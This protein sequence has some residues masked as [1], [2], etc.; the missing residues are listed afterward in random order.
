MKKFNNFSDFT[1]WTKKVYEKTDKKVVPIIAEQWYKDS[2]KYIYI[3]EKIMYKSAEIYSRFDEGII[4]YKTPYVRRRY[5]EGGKGKG[6]PE[7]Q[8]LWLEIAKNRHLKDYI[9]IYRK[10]FNEVKND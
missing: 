10:V 7:A 4:L 1:N 3:Q 6:N 2:E 8:P 9:A 5:Y